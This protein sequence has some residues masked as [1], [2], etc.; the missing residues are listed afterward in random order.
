MDAAVARVG[1]RADLRTRANTTEFY[2]QQRYNAADADA[3]L[4]VAEHLAAA[5]QAAG[6]GPWTVARAA[7]TL[8]LGPLLGRSLLQLSNG[9][10][11]RL[12]LAAALLKNP[13]LLLLDRPLA[14][15]DAA[16]RAGFDALLTEIAA[17]GVTLVVAH[18]PHR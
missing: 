18:G 16:S 2:Y 1:A 12:L 4:T 11:K 9:E 8:R 7:E 13:A 5:A 15:L 17:A 6:P 14:G 10:T 3:T